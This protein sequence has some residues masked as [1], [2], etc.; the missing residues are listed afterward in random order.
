[1]TPP[2]M[3]PSTATPTVN[4]PQPSHPAKSRPALLILIGAAIIA[5]AATC[6][7][8]RK[9]HAPSVPNSQAVPPAVAAPAPAPAISAPAA[10]TEPTPTTAVPDAALSSAAV[11]ETEPQPPTPSARNVGTLLILTAQD[12]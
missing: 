6:F 8:A 1:A 10:P 11:P 12:D 7:F 4:V 2:A 3:P 9:H 5:I